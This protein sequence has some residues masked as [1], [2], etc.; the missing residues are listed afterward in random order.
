MD[1]LQKE[2]CGYLKDLKENIKCM[3]TITEYKLMSKV[4]KES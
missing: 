2:Y 1:C 4:Q 3:I